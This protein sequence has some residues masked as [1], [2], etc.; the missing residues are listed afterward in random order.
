MWPPGHRFRV[1]GLDE[2]FS[3]LDGTIRA[4]IPLIPAVAAG[5]GDLTIGVTVHYQA[6][7]ETACLPPTVVRMGLP[8]REAPFT[9]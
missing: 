4:S 8:M 9:E 2:E 5:R 7:S 1:A 6:C 3:V